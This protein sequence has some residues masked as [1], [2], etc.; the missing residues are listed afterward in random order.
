MIEKQLGEYRIEAELGT[1]GMGRVYLAKDG[2][3]RRYALKVLHSHLISTEGLLARFLR[4]AKI[5]RRVQHPNVVRTYDVGEAVVEGQ[6]AHYLVMECVEGQ[7]LRELL[8]EL[9]RV[10]EELC[11]HIGREVARGLAAIHAAGVIHRDLKPENVLITEGHVVKVMDLGVARLTDE[12]IRLSHTG[13][14]AGSVLYAAPEQF[15]GDRDIDGRTDLYAIGLL[16]Y[17]LATGQHPFAH[18][19][20]RVTMQAQRHEPARP[21]AE[22]N[23]Q[24][25]PFFEFVVRTLLSKRR[26]DRFSSAAELAATLEQGERSAWWR[27]Q[28]LALRTA[29]RRPLRRIRI[30]RETALYGRDDLLVRLKDHYEQARQGAG[31]VVI[32]DG[33]A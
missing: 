29:T 22:L 3:G 27:A 7:T 32:L 8:G 10:P 9:G 21:V 11:R 6:S 26:D 14:F 20:I 24:L 16:L 5:G 25:S 31:Q 12:V 1:G 23:P 18:D 17:E 13:T 2:D 19:D 28:A 15:G 30:P 4:E 33:G